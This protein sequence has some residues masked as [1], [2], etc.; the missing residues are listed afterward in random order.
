MTWAAHSLK[1]FPC[2][3]R[4]SGRMQLH[5]LPPPNTPPQTPGPGKVTAVSPGH[6][7]GVSP[8]L[9][10][11][12]NWHKAGMSMP[13]HDHPGAVVV[14]SWEGYAAKTGISGPF[15]LLFHLSP[16]SPHPCKF[17]TNI[18]TWGVYLPPTKAR[19]FGGTNTHFL[20]LHSASHRVLE[21]ARRTH[22]SI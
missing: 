13:P 20:A 4:T 15:T 1:A 21:W 6:P 12:C 18:R 2:S 10:P 14:H 9:S 16:L 7:L 5:G 22:Q 8:P 19:I 17:C 11:L 3:D